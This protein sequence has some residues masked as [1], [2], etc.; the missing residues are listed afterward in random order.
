MPVQITCPYC[1]AALAVPDHLFGVP[2]QCRACSRTFLVPVPQPVRETQFHPLP[3]EPAPAV[4]VRRPAPEPATH[5]APG[6][7]EVIR[8]SARN[9]AWPA[10]C[11]CCCGPA[12]S[13]AEISFTR[14]EGFRRI[15]TD[16]RSHTV[17]VCSA[18]RSHRSAVAAVEA[19]Q[20]RLDDVRPPERPRPRLTPSPAPPSA[21]AWVIVAALVVVPSPFCVLG[22]ADRSHPGAIAALFFVALVIAVGFAYLAVIFTRAALRWEE[23]ER[24]ERRE[25]IKAIHARDD[26]DWQDIMAEHQRSLRGLRADLE[27]AEQA[28][29]TLPGCACVGQA[30]Y[31]LGWHGTVHTF[32]FRSPRY[33]ALFR[34]ANASK[35]A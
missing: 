15:R 29:E 6:Q 22:L 24:Q 35:L 16:A 3:V 4:V 19:I 7:S 14:T 23:N 2:V 20:R 21:A 26:Q 10:C 27:R 11:V 34:Q 33:A 12:D 17:P 13:S 32:E 18:C 30:V 31:Y 28:S 8:V 5:H 25:K 1:R 9:I